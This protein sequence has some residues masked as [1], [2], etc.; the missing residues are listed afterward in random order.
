V[1]SDGTFKDILMQE[2]PELW[3]SNR[4]V[5]GKAGAAGLAKIVEKV[6]ALEEEETT[7]QA[8][9]AEALAKVASKEQPEPEPEAAASPKKAAASKTAKKAAPRAAARK[10]KRP[11]P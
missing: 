10:T 5:A 3:H 9:D 4:P 8:R 7:Q 1:K 11:A 2:T 6:L